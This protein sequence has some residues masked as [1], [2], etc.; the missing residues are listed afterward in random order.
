MSKPWKPIVY[1]TM[2]RRDE[3][4]R[5]DYQQVRV[6]LAITIDWDGLAK[7]VGQKAFDN[8]S[9]KSRFLNGLILVKAGAPIR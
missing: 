9:K 6:P 4:G 5:T 8:R 1:L 3:T 2:K 7:V